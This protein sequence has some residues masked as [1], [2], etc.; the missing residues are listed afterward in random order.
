MIKELKKLR[1]EKKFVTSEMS[2][3]EI[4]FLIKHNPGMFREIFYERRVNNIYLDSMGLGNYNEN[5]AGNAQRLKLR[6]RWYGKIFGLI[7]KPVLELKIKNNELGDKKSFPLKPFLFDKSFSY[8]QLKKIFLESNLPDW[9]IEMLKLASPSLLNSYK[10]KYFLS[11]SKRY[12]I[13]LDKDLIYFKIIPENNS[14][15]EK[16]KE[17]KYVIELKYSVPDYLGA[18]PIGENLF[19]RLTANSKYVLGID[20]LEMQ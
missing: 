10:R 6:I 5:V 1:Y 9:L 19:L 8:K 12:R 14:F 20:S 16:V 18:I 3:K 13:T 11:A 17:D 15:C 7:K 2:L 4:E